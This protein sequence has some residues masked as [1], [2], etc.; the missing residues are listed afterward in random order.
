M[1]FKIIWHKFFPSLVDVPF[2]TLV[3]VRPRSNYT[4]RSSV[5]PD[6]NSYNLDGFQY[7]FAQL[8]SIMSWCAVWRFIWVGQRSRL[9]RLDKLSV[10]NLL[11]P[12]T[13]MNVNHPGPPWPSCLLFY[14]YFQKFFLQICLVQWS[15]RHWI[16]YQEIIM[17][18]SLVAITVKD[19][20][21]VMFVRQGLSHWAA[22]LEM[23][24]SKNSVCRKP[25]HEW[26]K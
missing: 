11:N 3:Q 2:E 17:H 9:C 20:E 15:F 5:W 25:I 24:K 21:N 8:F 23:V 26:N 16:H 19:V 4:W 13:D 22:N 1:D 7:T 18:S 12:L 6:H 10:D 14:R